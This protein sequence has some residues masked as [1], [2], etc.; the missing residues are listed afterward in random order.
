MTDHLPKIKRPRPYECAQELSEVRPPDQPG[1]GGAGG[2][3]QRTSTLHKCD[4]LKDNSR[5]RTNESLIC[6]Q[7]HLSTCATAPVST[8]S[9]AAKTIPRL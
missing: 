6:H 7:P 3:A 5:I 4:Q 2:V 8:D 1:P 9:T